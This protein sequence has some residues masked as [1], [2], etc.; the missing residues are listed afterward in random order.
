MPKEK[1]A[2]PARSALKN[3]VSDRQQETTRD[4]P[5]VKGSQRDSVRKAN[6][7]AA[8]RDQ[9]DAEYFAREKFNAVFDEFKKSF[10]ES[11]PVFVACTALPK[12]PLHRGKA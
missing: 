12:S 9:Q 1:E 4:E 2:D 7:D 11:L 8:P 3:N 5:I 6:W 10:P